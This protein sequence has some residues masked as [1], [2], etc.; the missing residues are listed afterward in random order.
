M[1]RYRRSAQTRVVSCRRGHYNAA[2]RGKIQSIFEVL[3]DIARGL[4]NC[5]AEID[6]ARARAYAIEDGLSEFIDACAFARN[7]PNQQ[8][9]ARTD[10]GRSRIAARHQNARR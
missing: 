1:A 4:R 5:D 6:D 9:A 10:R 7:R 3:G 8:S 2:G